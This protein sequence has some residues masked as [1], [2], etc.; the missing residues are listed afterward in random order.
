MILHG[1]SVCKAWIEQDGWGIVMHARR[2]RTT[3][4]ISMPSMIKVDMA[5]GY[6]IRCPPAPGIYHS[7]WDPRSIRTVERSSTPV[8]DYHAHHDDS[9]LGQISTEFIPLDYG[10]GCRYSLLSRGLLVRLDA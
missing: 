5:V 6:S 10:E 1:W 4:E 7:P 9:A 3:P 2:Y 8:D